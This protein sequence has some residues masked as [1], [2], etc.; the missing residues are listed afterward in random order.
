M[1]LRLLLLAYIDSVIDEF[2]R[3]VDYIFLFLFCDSEVWNNYTE[4]HFEGV[5]HKELREVIFFRKY[6]KHIDRNLHYLIN[7]TILQQLLKGIVLSAWDTNV[8]QGVQDDW[9]KELGGLEI[10]VALAIDVFWL[11]LNQVFP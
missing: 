1:C 8:N 9:T 2:F 3:V 11:L 7:V 10:Y 6:T 5:G 4:Q